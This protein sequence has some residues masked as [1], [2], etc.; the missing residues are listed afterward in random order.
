MLCYGVLPNKFTFPFV[1]K[2]VCRYW[3]FEVREI[4]SWMCCEVWF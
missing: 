1:L 4:G 2:R 3:E